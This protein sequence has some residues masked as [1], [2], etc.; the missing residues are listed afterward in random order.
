MAELNSGLHLTDVAKVYP[1]GVRAVDGV[2]LSVA[3]GEV[4]VLLGPSGCGKSTLLRCIN[5]LED[6]SAGSVT[7]EGDVLNAPGMKHAK[8]DQR[9]GM[10]FQSYEL[11]GHLNVIDNLL[12]APRIAQKRP[13]DEALAQAERLLTRVGLADRQRDM[14]NQLSGGQK[15]RVAIVRALMTNPE[16]LLLDEVTASLDPEMVREVLDVI[17]E[18]AA[19]GMTMVIVTHELAFARAIADE[20]VFLDAGQ[21]VERGPAERFFT[22][23]ATERAQRFLHNFTFEDIRK[24]DPGH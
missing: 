23:P 19:E 5:G 22:A 16:I 24:A 11:F 8:A 7:L 2:S 1:N 18:L 13:R 3:K 4:K 14:P 10:V 21:V 12:L 15:Q 9:V 6:I 17:L 20:I